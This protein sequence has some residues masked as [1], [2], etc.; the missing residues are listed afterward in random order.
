M[1]FRGY[2][3]DQM[4]L[5]GVD[6]ESMIPE[7]H[8][9]RFVSDLIDELDISGLYASYSEEG[10]PAYNPVMMLK[11]VVYAY[12][13]GIY[14]SR[15]IAKAIRENIHF[16]WLANYNCPDFRTINTFCWTRCKDL[17]ADIFCQVVIKADERGYLDY[18]SCF[19]DGST[20]RA[21]SG[22]YSYIW[23]KNALRYRQQVKQRVS[24]VLEQIEQI[25]QEE[26]L[27]YGDKD[28]NELGSRFEINIDKSG[29][30]EI[31]QKLDHEEKR[32]N[33][34]LG[35]LKQM[36]SGDKNVQ[37]KL[38]TLVRKIKNAKKDELAKLQKYEEQLNIIGDERNSASK[39]DHDATFIR[40]KDGEVAPGY[41][42]SIATSD[43]FVT[44][45]HLYKTNRESL[46]FPNLIE[47]MKSDYGRYPERVIGDAAYG[48][49]RNLHYIHT[50]GIEGFL[51][52][53]D[54]KVGYREST[55]PDLIYDQDKDE[56]T[57]TQ[58]KKFVLHKTELV[59]TNGPEREVR[60]Y[61][62][63]DCG[64]CPD[65][66][67]CI[68]RRDKTKRYIAYDPYITPIRKE[69]YNNVRSDEGRRLL[70][71]RCIEPEAV[72]GIIKWNRKFSRFTVR[73]L[74]KCKSQLMMVLLGYN[75]GKMYLH[76][77]R[78]AFNN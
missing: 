9:V 63:Y 62:C 7:K 67:K 17:L 37:K 34:V 74:K 50:A 8:L 14:T 46:E 12:M 35:K 30:E 13:N 33:A 20:F 40:M 68:Q 49:A 72:F 42:A 71:K 69:S 19:V 5:F 61:V 41:T 31:G 15:K 29:S 24:E 53:K 25:N 28:L 1:K 76:S 4:A 78:L 58:G 16:I 3:K 21:N 11:L 60:K 70:K 59:N 27:I 45:I 2:E 6:P 36:K 64:D 52:S 54:Y 43:Q 51:K 48:T 56:W 47:G 55:F 38:L 18:D 44:G 73:S 75:I 22:K 65:A 32:L 57:C 10:C 77:A 39:T 26:Q 23:K 66:N